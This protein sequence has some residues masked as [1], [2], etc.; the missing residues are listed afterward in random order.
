MAT[1]QQEPDPVPPCWIKHPL[2]PPHS[3]ESWVV[4]IVAEIAGAHRPLAVATL[5]K[6]DVDSV[7]CTELMLLCR[8]IV[9]IFSDPANKLAI[10][11]EMSLAADFY[12]DPSNLT[13]PVHE[14]PRMDD[15]EILRN[16][17][18]QSNKYRGIREFPFISSSL[19]LAGVLAADD[20]PI[21]MPLGT[22]FR[23]EN[24]YFGM[25]LFDI[26]NLEDL[27]YG[28]VAFQSQEMIFLQ[29]LDPWRK[30]VEMGTELGGTKELRVESERPRHAISAKACA[31]RF[32]PKALDGASAIEDLSVVEPIAFKLIWPSEQETLGETAHQV[33]RQSIRP[34]LDIT[35]T[36]LVE[37]A[38]DTE[39]FDLSLFDQPR[40]L[41][42]FKNA[43]QRVLQER[44]AN[45]G[46]FHSTAQL[47][48]LA[49]E[50]ETN[51]DLTR[52]RGLSVKTISSALEM[53][54]LCQIKTLSVC[55][56]FLSSSPVELALMLSRL[57]LSEIYLLQSA[58]RESDELSIQTLL[59]LFQCTDLAVYPSK[60]FVSGVYSAALRCHA[61]LPAECNVP[62]LLSPIQYIFQR[63]QTNVRGRP[64]KYWHW[65]SYYI[66]DGL[67][68]PLQF[69]AGLLNWLKRPDFGLY[70]FASGPP[71]LQ[72]DDTSRIEMTPIPADN[73]A[74]NGGYKSSLPMRKRLLR[75][76]SHVLISREKHWDRET[77]E[78]NVRT[79]GWEATE[80]DYVRFA[81]VQ[82]LNDVGVQAATTAVSPGFKREDVLVRGL[83]EFLG[84]TASAEGESIE[85]DPAIIEKRLEETGEYIAHQYGQ[86]RRPDGLEVVGVMSED[87]VLEA[88]NEMLESFK[89]GVTPM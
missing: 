76:S 60:I 27:K 11:S 29:T 14:V 77:H 64:R 45:I 83:K 46:Q 13:L 57:S 49:F 48:A 28:F 31:T 53:A 1:A 65:G 80:F 47:I 39:A 41:P 74:D 33:R 63:I 89:P 54:E 62:E 66:G 56:D 84:A 61:W 37:S 23:D 15:K 22:V 67:L 69:A 72:D 12:Q 25:V 51:L 16:I 30:W 6:T 79:G 19:L 73:I 26:S 18:A 40:R 88:L 85:V 36:T 86:G 68:N 50:G 32:E 10:A 2:S 81:F 42:N 17:G 87:E 7:G 44:S 70:R 9:S 35:V 24:P 38:T 4:Y 43:L 5:L 59:E 82:I 21:P 55:V 78:R 3:P 20:I 58:T 8:H 71:T 52:Y 75:G 34:L